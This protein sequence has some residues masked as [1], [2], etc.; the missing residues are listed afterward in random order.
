MNSPPNDALILHRLIEWNKRELPAIL[1]AYPDDASVGDRPKQSGTV[2][3]KK[4]RFPVGMR[5]AAVLPIFPS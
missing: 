3:R 5:S 1:A 2:E 4:C